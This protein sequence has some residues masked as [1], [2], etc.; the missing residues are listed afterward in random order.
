MY[1]VNDDCTKL[2][3]ASALPDKIFENIPDWYIYVVECSSDEVKL[4]CDDN[5]SEV[6]TFVKTVII[7]IIIYYYNYLYIL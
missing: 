5:V 7:I 1:I 2:A 4:L 3:N 6:H